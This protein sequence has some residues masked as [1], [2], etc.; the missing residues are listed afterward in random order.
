MQTAAEEQDKKTVVRVNLKL[1]PVLHKRLKL[2]VVNRETNI[3]DYIEAL[4]R[5]ALEEDKS[6][7]DARALA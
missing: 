5:R 6:K 3:Q 7:Q 2:H 1:D 4:V